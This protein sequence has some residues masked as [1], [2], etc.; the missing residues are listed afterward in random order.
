MNRGQSLPLGASELLA[1]LNAVQHALHRGNFDRAWDGLLH[2]ARELYEQ[3]AAMPAAAG[4]RNLMLGDRFRELAR[5]LSAEAPEQFV[6]FNPIAGPGG[7]SGELA[8]EPVPALGLDDVVGQ[9]AVKELFRARYLYPRQAPEVAARFGQ[10]GGGGVLLY[11]LPGNGKTHLV[12]CLAGELGA[13]TFAVN[14]AAVLSKWMGEAE[15]KLA[16][17]FDAARRSSCALLFIDEIDAFAVD[18]E[19]GGDHAAMSRLLSQLLTELDGFSSSTGR[20]L[21]IGATNRP[22]A[23]DAALLR[24]GR[25]DGL[26]LV[27]LPGPGARRQLLQRALA[28]LPCAASLDLDEVVSRLDAYSAKEVCLV[29]ALAAQRAFVDEIETG[30]SQYVETSHLLAAIGRVHRT[31]TPDARERLL[32]FARSRGLASE[33]RGEGAD[34]PVV[35]AA[36]TL[37]SAPAPHAASRSGLG[38]RPVALLPF[39]FVHA[40]DLAADLQMLPFVSY[41]LQHVG[42]NPVQRLVIENQGQEPSQNLV[43][44]LSLVPEDF[45]ASWTANIAELSPM[46]QWQADN[47]SLPLRLDRLRAVREREM[48]HVQLLVLD[49][50]QILFART[51]EVPVLAYNEWVF[52]EDLLELMVAFVQPNAPELGAVIAKAA[53]RLQGR[54]GS[55]SFSGYQRGN[56]EHVMQMLASLHDALLHDCQLAYIN[57][58]PSFE[59]TGQKVRLVAETLAQGRGTCLDLAVLQ[60]ALWEHVGLHPV[61]VLVPGHALL[62]CW[63]VERENLVAGAPASVRYDLAEARPM[64]RAV[65]D[66]RLVFIN[67]VEV[68]TGEPLQA[69]L[70]NARQIIEM[71]LAA[72]QYVHVVDLIVARERVRPLP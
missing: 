48:A 42:I 51:Q 70:N 18:R 19:Q 54:Y 23:M 59:R 27:D 3:A 47:V 36:P 21:F 17:V 16:E 64:Q 9:D 41:A 26:A 25:F 65:Q 31:A 45:G 11:G 69:A 29:A 44:E 56:R 71:A 61:M 10:T 32:D 55:S 40:R 5:Q 63:V 52:H 24:A 67:S 6:P 8:P 60:A 38:G 13:E 30:R 66:G 49:K 53:E 34:R 28:K 46:G 14:P 35:K 2:T 62:G 7:G 58:P 1:R 72:G 57:P 50:D 12:R 43:V 22:W 4:R 20:L 37:T 39:R 33:G 68:A 15:R